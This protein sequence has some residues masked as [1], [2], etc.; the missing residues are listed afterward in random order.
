MAAAPAIVRF[1]GGTQIFARRAAD[2]EPRQLLAY[3]MNVELDEELAMVLPLPVPPGPAEDSVRF[4][5]LEGYA[6]FF[7]D[8]ASAFPAAMQPA[9]RGFALSAAPPPKLVVHD[10]GRFEASFVPTR[11]DFARL[12]PRFRM[13]EGTWDRL[14][15]YADWGFAVFRLRPS[16]GLLGGA[17][18]QSVHPMAFSFPTREP[19]A[20][21]FPTVHVHDGAVHAEAHFDHA[22]Y[23]QPEGILEA[24]LGWT[25]SS[26]PLGAHVDAARAKGLVDGAR[27]GFRE[28]L[29]GTMPNRD[30]WLRPPPGVT[31]DDLQGSGECHAYLLDARYAFSPPAAEARMARW[32]ETSRTRLAALAQGLRSGLPALC[33]AQRARWRLAPLRP[34]LPPHFVNGNQ[35]WTG[36]TYMDGAPAT[37][38]GPGRVDFTA[39]SEHV[40]PQKVTLGFAAVPD[41]DTVAEIQREL[42][43][44]VDRA[45]ASP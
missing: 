18:K 42:A 7:D 20:L 27:G 19:D 41:A 35:L 43:R 37:A 16:K 34:E 33:A 4:I 17:K 6:R 21:F 24:M 45:V 13:P 44:L 32:Q 39:W 22:L 31:T 38:S 29:V 15:E 28:A 11:A 40:P 2:A 3:A 12:D 1:V 36:R 14:P 10:V 8:V 30:T 26:G 23:A 25:R 5:D 9:S